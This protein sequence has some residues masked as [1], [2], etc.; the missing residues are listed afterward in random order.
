[1]TLTL[2][3]FIYPFL[4]PNGL[5]C[6]LTGFGLACED[7]PAELSSFFSVFPYLV[8]V[9]GGLLGWRFNRTRLL[10]AILLF[11]LV[12]VSLRSVSGDPGR[13]LLQ[14]A[15]VLLP[16]NL[17]LVLWFSERGLVNLRTVA[18]LL[19]LSAEFSV[20]VW[21]LRTHPAE[22]RAYLN[23]PL[24]EVPFG[25]TLFLSQPALF[26]SLLALLFFAWRAIRTSAA[27]DVSF[28]WAQ[29]VLILG[30]ST[31]AGQPLR[32]YLASAGLLLLLGIVEMSHSLA[33][34]DELTGLPGRRALYEDL[35]KLGSCYS[36]AMLDIDH[37]K[38]FND[39]HGHVVGDQV[40]RM[41]ASKLSTVG[42]GGKVFRFGGEEFSVIFPRRPLKEALPFLE[43]L[44]SAVEDARFIPRG[45]DRSKKK[46]KKKPVGKKQYPALKVTISIGGAERSEKL[47]TAELIIDAAD[48]ALYRAKKAGRNRVCI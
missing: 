32:L 18:W 14:G 35:V 9:A 13:I 33:Y 29:I 15:A 27:F 46:P 22:M 16:P 26:S 7:L 40:L 30:F 44:R 41:V 47:P 31:Y 45:K 25:G 17:L 6:L 10:F 5:L 42:G 3:K 20:F 23:Y 28:F 2:K 36:L 24:F 34:R 12:D 4:L 39:T 48:K 21:L 11:V 43:L 37:F 8:V 38:K 1:L 19:F